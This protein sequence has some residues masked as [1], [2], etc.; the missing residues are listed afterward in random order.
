MSDSADKIVLY[1]A[2]DGQPDIRLRVEVGICGLED[3]KAKE[4][5]KC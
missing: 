1:P 4:G 5:E 2:N 3:A